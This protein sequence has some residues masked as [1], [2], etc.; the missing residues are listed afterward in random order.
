MPVADF[1]VFSDFNA[2]LLIPRKPTDL[3]KN[4]QPFYFPSLLS[5]EA[6]CAPNSSFFVRPRGSATKVAKVARL[7]RPLP[8][9][10]TS[11]ALPR[12]IFSTR[13]LTPMVVFMMELKEMVIT[14]KRL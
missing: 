5:F 6:R 14:P 7:L 9:T 8:P 1:V 2:E 4:L 13:T 10:P 12:G 3:S 11:S